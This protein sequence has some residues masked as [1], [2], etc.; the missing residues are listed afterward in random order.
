MLRIHTAHSTRHESA[1]LATT[2]GGHM[3]AE[4]RV[5]PEPEMS[6]AAGMLAR[7]QGHRDCGP[8]HVQ[9]AHG[10]VCASRHGLARAEWRTFADVHE[11]EVVPR[12]LEV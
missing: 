4:V 10:L 11:A 2:A 7:A 1:L 9:T 5:E 6:L 8:A 12:I 3:A